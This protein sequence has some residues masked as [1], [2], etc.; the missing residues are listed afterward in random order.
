MKKFLLTLLYFSAIAGV[1]A[2]M[3][4]PKVKILK[5]SYEEYLQLESRLPVFV[6][7]SWK[8]EEIVF[9]EYK[10][11]LIGK[12]KLINYYLCSEGDLCVVY[13][14]TFKDKRKP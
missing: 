11:P 7:T 3:P 8:Q 4:S 14:Y 5:M 9:D 6:K 10:K 13:K 1:S 12:V 2:Q